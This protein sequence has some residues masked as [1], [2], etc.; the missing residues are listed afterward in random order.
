MV[1]IYAAILGSNIISKEERDKTAE[2]I[3]VKPISRSYIITSK[4]VAAFVNILIFNIITLISSITI[5]SY[6][7]KG[8]DINNDIFKL[9]IGLFLLQL[10]FLSMG[11]AISAINK[12]PRSSISISTGI[13]L[14][15]FILSIVIDINDKLNYLRFYTP[16]K[17]FQ[18]KDLMYGGQFEWPLLILSFALIVTFFIITYLFY[19]KKD[20]TI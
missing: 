6:F 8:E 20:L 15:M 10:I 3:Y 13:L 1:G 2:F 18:A 14:A 19:N 5:V 9:I 12:K 16:F 17:Y 7:G 11:T 4:L